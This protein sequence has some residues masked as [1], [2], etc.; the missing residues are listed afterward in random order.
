MISSFSLLH[1]SLQTLIFTLTIC[2]KVYKLK[3]SAMLPLEGFKGEPHT[4]C[5]YST[6]ID[7]FPVKNQSLSTTAYMNT[8]SIPLVSHLGINS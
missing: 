2:S 3:A 7:K 5:T 1:N 8:K 6:A 4:I